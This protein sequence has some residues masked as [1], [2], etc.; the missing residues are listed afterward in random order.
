MLGHADT[1]ITSK[2]YAH[3]ADKPLAA[4]VA[5]LPSFGADRRELIAEVSRA[6][7]G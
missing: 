2:H 1:R 3:M 7:T 6:R 5:K 4:A